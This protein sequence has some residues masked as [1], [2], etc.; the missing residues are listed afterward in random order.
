MARKPPEVLNTTT[1]LPHKKT[2]TPNA[3]SDFF[4]VGNSSDEI[5]MDLSDP[6]IRKRVRDKIENLNI[7]F[8]KY[9]FPKLKLLMSNTMADTNAQLFESI[10]KLNEL[11]ELIIDFGNKDKPFICKTYKA[12]NGKQCE[13]MQI[14]KFANLKLLTILNTNFMYIKDSAN[15]VC[16]YLFLNEIMSSQKLESIRIENCN[17]EFGFLSKIMINCHQHRIKLDLLKVGFFNNQVEYDPDPLCISQE[18]ELN[19][20]LTTLKKYIDN[21]T[22]RSLNAKFYAINLDNLGEQ[23]DGPRLNC[24]CTNKACQPIDLSQY[25]DPQ[26]LGD[27]QDKLKTINGSIESPIKTAASSSLPMSK[28]ESPQIITDQSEK[29]Q[30]EFLRKENEE[31][32]AEVATLRIQLQEA[33]AMYLK[34]IKHQVDSGL[35]WQLPTS[36]T[37]ASGQESAKTTAGSNVSGQPPQQQ[38]QKPNLKNPPEPQRW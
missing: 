16:S 38:D 10:S 2:W 11:E 5:V 12:T 27:F 24:D 18:E 31:L 22:V 8:T 13:G 33:H 7:L 9:N 23:Y 35:Y 28:T 14:P 36:S 6:A 32:K 19:S 4:T 34:E 20:F 15:K 1:S 29:D 37:S 17:V 25:L 3:R 21:G 26:S 30:M